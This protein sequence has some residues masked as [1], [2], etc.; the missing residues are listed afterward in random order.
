MTILVQREL[1]KVRKL[2]TTKIYQKF[3]QKTI[4]L[5]VI[6]KYL[7][8]AQVVPLLHR[9]AHRHRVI[10][11]VTTSLIVIH[12]RLRKIPLLLLMMAIN[13]NRANGSTVSKS[14][15]LQSRHYNRTIQ[16]FRSTRVNWFDELN[17]R[18]SFT[19]NN[20]LQ[21]YTNQ[22]LYLFHRKCLMSNTSQKKKEW[23]RMEEK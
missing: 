2:H 15:F 10:L 9:S 17:T 20:D 18:R 3:L 19:S 4:K 13:S 11:L 6:A 21:W 14:I 5:H 12:P 1:T 22:W 7:R 23:R 8:Q 16:W